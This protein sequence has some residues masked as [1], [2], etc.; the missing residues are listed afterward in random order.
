ML[1]SLYG[2]G[3][4][5][6]A[7]V[8]LFCAYLLIGLW[9]CDDY[10]V[11]WDE[12]I[13][14]E[15]GMQTLDYA[16]WT[17]GIGSELGPEV[18]ARMR[19]AVAEQGPLFELVLA[20]MEQAFGLEDSRAVLLMR[21]YATFM[22][23]WCGALAFY[24]LLRRTLS[25]KLFAL[26]GAALLITTPRLFAHAFYNSKDMVLLAMMVIATLSMVVF[27]ERR[28]WRFALLHAITCAITID[29]RIVGVLI[30]VLT[31]FFL[32]LQT[33]DDRG[34]RLRRDLMLSSLFGITLAVCVVLF[35]PQLWRAP[36]SG[37]VDIVASLGDARQIDNAMA[38][39]AGKF[40]PV[41][42]LP[43]YYL[44]TWMA[45]TIPP[46]IG[47]LFLVGLGLSLT[48][49]VRAPLS[50]ANRSAVLFLLLLFLPLGAV[51]A[52][53]P[54]LYDGW[55]HF[56]FVYPA[57][58]GVAMLGAEKLSKDARLRGATLGIIVLAI[59]FSTVALVRDHPYQH[60]YFNQFAGGDLEQTFEL[61]YWGLSFREGF[62][63]VLDR[64]PAGVIRV[65]VSD[66]P[67]V[68]NRMI[69]DKAQRERLRI[70]KVEDADYFLS[71]HRNPWHFEL[72]QDG[73]FPYV[74]EVQAIRVGEARILGIYRLAQ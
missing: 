8:V 71:N 48:A 58:L 42:A 24:C 2:L 27:L 25:E 56:Y 38:L 7:P 33:L 67:G 47:L 49:L 45:I 59:A 43:W 41:D 64:E 60:V 28:T 16:R 61:D 36:V 10:G 12:Q 15:F 6:G 39:F 26:L 13:N 63:A 34:V 3:R 74:N 11:S 29:I 37:V 14:R 18:E 40:I 65:A 73:R 5:R 22:V 57:L 1:E 9:L 52:L 21:H 19:S 4:S 55:R 32:G 51:L 50:R 20:G 31:L 68:L 54:V 72:F 53:R 17:L 44:P 30:P 23:F 35:W 70:V 69:L 66:V 62:E 46:L